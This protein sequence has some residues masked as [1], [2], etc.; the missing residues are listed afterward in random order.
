LEKTRKM[1]PE[2][3]TG[4]AP[5]QTKTKLKLFVYIVCFVPGTA[6]LEKHTK[7]SR[8]KTWLLLRPQSPLRLPPDG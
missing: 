7:L 8:M 3:V 5:V 4:P 6:P 2:N 1:G